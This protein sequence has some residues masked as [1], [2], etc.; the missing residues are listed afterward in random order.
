MGLLVTWVV[1]VPI[2]LYVPTSIQRRFLDGYQTPLAL[3]GAWGIWTTLVRLRHLQIRVVT[4]SISIVVMMLS[5]VLLIVSALVLVWGRTGP[6][7]RPVGEQRA[8]DWLVHQTSAEVVLSDYVT[9]NFIPTRGPV[10][11]FLG[12]GPETMESEEK[13]ELVGLFFD[14]TTD[15]TWRRRLLKQYGVDTIFWGPAER[16]LGGFDPQAAPYL[17]QIYDKHEYAIFEFAP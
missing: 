14:A 15:D 6:V 8:V 7:F 3:L 10:R 11:V 9:G 2:L 5:N 12:H 17:R 16:A 1:A 13:R 4:V